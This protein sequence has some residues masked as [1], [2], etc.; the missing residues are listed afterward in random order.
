V[1]LFKSIPVLELGGE[2][3]P[4][5]LAEIKNPPKKLYYQGAL[6]KK[7]FKTCLAVVGTR[8]MTDYGEEITEKFV[9]S[10]ARAG[11]TI[12]SGF[13]Y[14]IDAVAHRACLESGG[15]TIAVLG[16]G[17]DLVRP[18]INR[19]LRRQILENK[20]LVVSELPGKHPPFRW[21]FVRRN[22]IIS[23]LSKAILVVE[24]GEKSGALI[25]AEFARKQK[26]K[27]LAI[28][29]PITSAVSKGTGYLIRQGAKLVSTP[30]DVLLE[31]GI[32]PDS[33]GKKSNRNRI[34]N[35]KEEKILA[36]LKE[37]RLLIDEIARGL[38]KPVGQVGQLISIMMLKGL[39]KQDRRERYYAN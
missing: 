7:I 11:V 28:P 34:V 22:R 17:I 1:L 36:L 23:G 13:M 32:S 2:K 31:L 24:A 25:I 5:L 27:V 37:K 39:V 38:D 35:K 19:D 12:V 14:G 9:S 29:G 18:V 4:R 3:Y 8:K 21:T 33:K 10:I 16:C 6:D 15:R 26:R 20:G 30:D